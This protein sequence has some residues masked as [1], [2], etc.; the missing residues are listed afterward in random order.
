MNLIKNFKR[1]LIIIFL[2]FIFTLFGTNI[3]YFRAKIQK[4][5]Q[6]L[7]T[8]KTNFEKFD[9]EKSELQNNY[10]KLQNDYNKLQSDYQTISADRENLMTQVKGLLADRTLARE[11]EGTV[12]KS[13]TDMEALQKDKQAILDE[14]ISLQKQI[15]DFKTTQ[16]QLIKEREQLAA[17]LEKERAKSFLK[18]LEQQKASLQKENSELLNKLKAVE[19]SFSKLKDSEAKTRENL[20]KVIK[21]A[22]ALKDKLDRANQGYAAAIEKNKELQR[23]V[24]DLPQKFSEIARQN[25]VLIRQTSNMHYNLGVFYTKQKDYSR[26]IAEFEKAVEL[27][28]DDAYAHFNLGYIYAEYVVNRQKAIGHFQ[29]YLRFAKKD[30]KDVDWVKKYILT[31]ESWQGK[32][33][34]E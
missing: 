30:D 25:K 20:S 3:Y 27:T 9:K 31:W 10:V 28:P 23:K 32:Q 8:E 15:E 19:A 29:K 4:L 5:S 14:N 22:D 21:E 1:I 11:L 6:E 33:P 26:A 13:K 16:K 7:Q 17:T 34:M 24:A 18:N 2:L 12:E